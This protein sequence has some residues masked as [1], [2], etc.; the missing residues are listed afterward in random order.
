MVIFSIVDHMERAQFNKL[1]Q[2]NTDLHIYS[3]K[4][5]DLSRNKYKIDRPEDEAMQE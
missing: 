2:D 1:K 3:G 5:S 4:L